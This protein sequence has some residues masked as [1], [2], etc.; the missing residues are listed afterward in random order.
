MNGA[1]PLPPHMPSWLGQGKYFLRVSL[2]KRNL[3]YGSHKIQSIKL[4]L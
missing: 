4:R 3:I 1:I 2:Q